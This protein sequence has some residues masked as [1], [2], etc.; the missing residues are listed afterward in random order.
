MQERVQLLGGQF[1]I[2]SIPGQGTTVRLRLQVPAS[3]G[4]TADE[5]S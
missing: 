4:E 3:E 1:D 5:V 2:E